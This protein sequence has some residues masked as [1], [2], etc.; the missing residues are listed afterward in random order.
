[1]IIHTDDDLRSSPF[2]NVQ[3]VFDRHAADTQTTPQRRKSVG[4]Q[5]LTELQENLVG[6]PR[7]LSLHN[8]TRT[9]LSC[10]LEYIGRQ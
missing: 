5:L 7:K 9:H 10:R 6:L 2:D 8:E 4:L 3:L 1:M